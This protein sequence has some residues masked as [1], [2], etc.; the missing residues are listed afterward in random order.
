M[1]IKNYKRGF[2]LLE[3]LVVVLIIGILAAI[4]L[5]QYRKAVIKTRLAEADIA[6]NT[7]MKNMQLYLDANGYPNPSV[8][9][10][11][12]NAIS[13][14]EMPGDCSGTVCQTNFWYFEA[15]CS[16]AD[17]VISCYTEGKSNN[18]W[19]NGANIAL[20]KVP[21]L[22][23]WFIGNLS[24]EESELKI[25]CQWAK[26]RNFKDEGRVCS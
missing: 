4:A 5:P 14:I 21:E 3:L 17:C 10:T 7:M 25:L 22:N 9:F 11:G 15:Y 1:K 2:T 19:L 20:V 13:E 8:N 12:G 26:E 23:Y 24:A 6:I 18:N 16:T